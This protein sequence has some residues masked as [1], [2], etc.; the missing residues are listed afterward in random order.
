MLGT[1]QTFD[2]DMPNT[3]CVQFDKGGWE[4][5]P[6]TSGSLLPKSALV[7]ND[8]KACFFYGEPDCNGVGRAQHEYCIT[9]SEASNGMW[10]NFKSFRCDV[11]LSSDAL[12]KSRL[13]I[14][15]ADTYQ[16][17]GSVDILA[18]VGC[19]N[20]VSTNICTNDCECRCNAQNLDCPKGTEDDPI[21]VGC[22]HWALQNCVQNCV[23][24][25]P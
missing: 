12:N 13:H 16:W 5:G 6:C 23:C 1:C 4:N 20:G 25:N 21:P 9:A 11:S 10:E 18:N 22:N 2:R 17:D 7:N 24:V 19:K 14:K 3:D 15:I 8:L